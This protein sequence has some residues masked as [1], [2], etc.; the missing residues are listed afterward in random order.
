MLQDCN[1]WLS[2]SKALLVS[3][4]TVAAWWSFSDQKAHDSYLVQESC[5]S[6]NK[7]RERHAHGH[8][9]KQDNEMLNLFLPCQ[10]KPSVV[11]FICPVV[12]C[13]W[14]GDDNSGVTLSG[15]NF[16]VAQDDAEIWN[17]MASYSWR[18]LCYTVRMRDIWNIYY[19]TKHSCLDLIV[20]IIAYYWYIELKFTPR[21]KMVVAMC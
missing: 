5:V 4:E 13:I 8:N 9:S 17:T 16:C 21:T 6:C 14:H 1:T 19:L 7:D 3:I 18:T 10:H 20:L 12:Y 15:T 2:G 11:T